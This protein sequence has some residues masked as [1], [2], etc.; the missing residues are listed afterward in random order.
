MTHDSLHKNL[1]E[2]LNS[3]I[4]LGT[5]KSLSTAK[6]WL[7]GTFLYVRLKENPE[8]YH[9]EDQA[10][11]RDLD[12]RLENICRNG[13]A[14]LE[15]H[16][17]VRGN[18]KLQSTEFGDAMARYYIKFDTMKNLLALPQ[19]AKLS[20]ILSVIA[21]AA[22][23]KDIRFRAG[24]KS[25]Y[26]DLNKNGSIKFQIPVN[27][28]AP[29]HKV[30][31]IIQSTLGAI[32]LPTEEN[33]HQIE[34]LAAKST[35]FQHAHR[36][37]R[38]II[39]CQLY[40]EDSTSARN[41]LMLARSFGAHVW[42]DSSLHMMQLEDLGI[43]RT[44]KLVAAGIKSI[45]D[46]ESA[47]PRRIETIVSRN[48]PYGSR[49]QEQAKAFPRLRIALKAVGQPMVQKGECVAVKV[50]A[51]IG[52]I[53]D[54]TPDKFGRKMVYVCLLADTSDGR[55]AHFA[56]MSAK[57]LG[58][59]Q[60]VM[61][62]AKLT[63]PGQTIRGFIMCDEFA[64]TQRTAMLNPEVPDFMFPTPKAI[65]EAKKQQAA[66]PNAPNT[67]KRR[68]AAAADPDW[69]LD[70]EDFGDAGLDDAALVAAENDEFAN[71][72]DYDDDGN[73]KSKPK[74]KKSTNASNDAASAND[75]HEPQ[76]LANGRWA[77]NH[78]CSDK[79]QC[80]HLCCREG[81]EKPPKAPKPK[82]SKKDK[83]DT[84]PKQTKLDTTGMKTQKPSVS[85]SASTAPP[86]SL[87]P[88]RKKPE[89]KEARD[90]DRIHNSVKSYTSSVPLLKNKPTTN[91]KAAVP[92]ATQ[93]ATHSHENAHQI[94]KEESDYGLD[95]LDD[96]DLIADLGMSATQTTSRMGLPQTS[97]NP[98][99]DDEDLLGDLWNFKQT[100]G[101]TDSRSLPAGNQIQA[102]ND[103]NEDDQMLD[104]DVPPR[105]Q[106][107]T[108]QPSTKHRPLFITGDTSSS[109]LNNNHASLNSS[110][111]AREEN[112][113][114]SA[115]FP[116]PKKRKD[117]MAQEFQEELLL[118]DTPA[119]KSDDTI[120]QD[121][122]AHAAR[123]DQVEAEQ[124][125]DEDGKSKDERLKDWFE[126][127]FGLEM[128]TF[129]D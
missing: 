57:Q 78:K 13:L 44:R 17:L 82:E 34:Y 76:Q 109:E 63:S 2:H 59:G 52:F 65:E 16:D 46:I 103:D 11:G 45:E 104:N 101:F 125:Q 60:D 55:L 112:T 111:H 71:I 73:E 22:E 79:T 53:N 124:Q 33:K 123:S 80:K 7:K 90:L 97:T 119:L 70:E 98:N 83:H 43:V 20:E 24:E 115:F 120:M 27:V 51:E 29:A 10:P 118:P 49:L 105:G 116:P 5:V 68:S 84:D 67:A 89:S 31:L 127:E 50:K 8:H 47:D 12:E 122:A 9:I 110:K 92:S 113:A 21:Q 129:A 36:L 30:S 126:K 107:P 128:F 75:H 62:T 86:A 72:D 61:F 4:G 58:K 40:L 38:C 14:S 42:D 32:E 108:A 35:I 88:A 85:G 48:V 102:S 28:D 41:A 19:Q 74:R 96:E 6:K 66:K 18:T 37:T 95:S 56:R 81:L 23:F 26:R 15:E 106:S 69:R 114:A 91:A 64:G 77:C 1:T 100:G 99:D 94:E 3:E 25:V 39:D 117:S 121:V 93:S 54:K 87:A